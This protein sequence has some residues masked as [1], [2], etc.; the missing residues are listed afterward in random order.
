MQIAIDGPA[1]S[2]KST[3]AKHIA[4]ILG[5]IYIDTGAMYR[6]VTYEILRHNIEVQ[7]LNS[8]MEVLQSM[9]ISFKN[10]ED[11]QGVFNHEE[12]ISLAIRSDKV[13]AK[14][15]EISAIAEVR[16][17]LVD[18][19]RNLALNH[20]VI[21]DGRD[22]G[23]VVLPQA[24]YK[25]YLVASSR[26]RAQRRYDENIRRGISTESI[27]IIEKNI[28]KRDLYDSQ[29]AHSPLTKAKDAIEIDTSELTIQEVVD[30]ILYYINS[31]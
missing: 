11:G 4:N 2:G 28:I 25:F 20:D 12:D 17:F 13:T 14:V 1:S 29:R 7:E 5:I 19:Q 22:I 24:D 31:K 21:M 8:I 23:T 16:S 18:L 9:N 6:A 15:S 10:K 27:D 26:V 30:N 3:V